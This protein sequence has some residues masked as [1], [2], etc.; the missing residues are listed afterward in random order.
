MLYFYLAKFNCFVFDETGCQ[1][2]FLGDVRYKNE[3]GI[4]PHAAEDT[5]ID[6]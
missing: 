2:D 4:G 1:F 3:Y 6:L 5:N